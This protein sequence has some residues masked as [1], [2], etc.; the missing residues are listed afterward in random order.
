[1]YLKGHRFLEDLYIKMGG[2]DRNFMN[3]AIAKKLSL[4]LR[5][6]GIHG[7]KF[8]D[9]FSRGKGEGSFNYVISDASDIETIQHDVVDKKTGQMDLFT[10]EQYVIPSQRASASLVRRAGSEV[11]SALRGSGEGV[12][13]EFLNSLFHDA[14]YEACINS[15]FSGFKGKFPGV[16]EGILR[17]VWS[18]TKGFLGR[19]KSSI[20]A[21]FP[22]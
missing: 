8:L 21:C 3:K 4:D 11:L 14:V 22:A 16:S 12:S 5:A 2:G 1:M 10:Q 18:V 9:G 15:H 17:Q 6:A 13:S 19:G 7:F 20:Q